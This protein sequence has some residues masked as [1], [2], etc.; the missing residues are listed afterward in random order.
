MSGQGRLTLGRTN[1]E[2]SGLRGAH[3][4]SAGDEPGVTGA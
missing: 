2:P 1:T 4:E 3:S